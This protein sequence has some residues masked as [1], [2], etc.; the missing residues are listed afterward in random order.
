MTPSTHEPADAPAADHSGDHKVVEDADGLPA[1][2]V[3]TD[4]AVDDLDE[5]LVGALERIGHLTRTMIAR[6][7]YREG[8]SAL[9]LQLLLRIGGHS[10][11]GRRMSDLA[12]ELDV[13]Q[14]TISDALGTLRRKELV[15]REQDPVD[16]RSSVFA[17]TD[18]GR[19]L[20][21][22]LEAWDEP[23]TEPMA[24]LDDVDKGTTLRVVLGLV[25]ELHGAGV[26]NVARTCLTCRFFDDVTHPDD[27]A[28]YRCTLL[29]VAFT[30]QHLRVDCQEH[31]PASAG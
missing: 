19:R 12:T 21:A 16:R 6:Q 24:A 31:E 27:V 15:T 25:A 20:C 1:D 26:I 4:S 14:A 17:L 28:P 10:R 29:D 11:T 3:T 7:A 30:D 5:R 8:V 13:S 23:L 2:S 18:E 9:Q 22:R